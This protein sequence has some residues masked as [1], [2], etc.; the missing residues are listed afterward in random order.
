MVAVMLLAFATMAAPAV[1]EDDKQSFIDNYAAVAISEMQFSG[2]PASITLAQAILESSWGRGSIAAEAN[3]YFCIKCFNGWEGPTFNAKDDEP[4]LSCFRS[5]GSVWESFRDHSNFLRDGMRYQLLF[6]IE[7]TD[8]QAWAK[9]LSQ[10]GYA[11]DKEYD[12]KLIKLIQEHGLWIYD[13]AIPEQ[14]FGVLETAEMEPL[15]TG[16]PDKPTEETPRPADE[17]LLPVVQTSSMLSVP[18]YRIN[19][20]A[21][22]PEDSAGR[23]SQN[24]EKRNGVRKMK[25]RPIVPNPTLSVDW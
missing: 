1:T 2:I 5:Y 22:E 10:S 23:R 21:D 25:I 3:N 16:G 15:F 13:F 18:V 11:T 12:E 24:P 20:E 7:K 6:E 9:G 19:R 14:N 4:G 17:Q 8:F